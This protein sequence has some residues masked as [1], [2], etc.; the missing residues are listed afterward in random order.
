IMTQG[1]AAGLPIPR[2]I[3]A[4]DKEALRT[5]E[6]RPACLIEFLN[7]VS[8]SSPSTAQA[9]A[10][11]SL[12]ARFHL[13]LS[14]TK[15]A[16]DDT[17][18]LEGWDR[19][20]TACAEKDETYPEREL[21]DS[22]RVAQRNFWSAAD[23]Q[24]LPHGIIHADLFPDNVLFTGDEVTGMIDFYFAATGAFVY[25]IAVMINSW[26]MVEGGDSVMMRKPIADALLAGYAGERPLTDAEETALPMMLRAAA[27]RFL[28]TRRFDALHPA[29]DALVKPKD[30]KPFADRLRFFRLMDNAAVFQKAVRT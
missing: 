3:L 20:G 17:L 18:M 21:V 1:Q 5:I 12:L 6:G 14:E 29:T 7:G 8:V 19:L 28:L 16:R 10:A 24:Q 4:R 2:P 30:P 22:E 23:T 11:G 15:L 13:A 27:L 26:A 25:D 9:R